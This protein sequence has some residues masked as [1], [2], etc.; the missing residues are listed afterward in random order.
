MTRDYAGSVPAPGEAT[1]TGRRHYPPDLAQF[2]QEAS[3]GVAVLEADGAVRWC[4][5]AEHER[6][7]LQR[8]QF[9]GRP[10]REVFVTPEDCDRLLDRLLKGAVVSG[11]VV[12]LRHASGTL[13]YVAIDGD[14]VT[15]DDGLH[16]RLLTRDVTAERL[17]QEEN[18]LQGAMLNA[19]GQAVVGTDTDGIVTY[20]NAAAERMFGVPAAEALGRDVFKL[21]NTEGPQPSGEEIIAA[22]ARGVPW[23][24]EVE[25]KRPDGSRLSVFV[26]ETP[27]LDADGRVVGYVGVSADISAL[28]EAAGELRARERR[29]EALAESLPAMVVLASNDRGFYYFNRTFQQYTGL[30]AAP[31]VSYWQELIHPD[32]FPSLREGFQRVLRGRA[33]EREARIRRHDGEF[34]WFLI[35]AVPLAPSR[36]EPG[37]AVITAVDIMDIRAASQRLESAKNQL[38]TILGGITDGVTAHDRSG[39]MVFANAAAARLLGFASVEELLSAPLTSLLRN[40]EVEDQ[41]GHRLKARDLPGVSVMRG[42]HPE[43]QLLAYK[44]RV[45]G[46]VRYSLV[47]AAAIHDS[48]GELEYVVDIFSDVTNTVLAAREREDLLQREREARISAE[49]TAYRLAALQEVTAS[50]AGALTQQQIAEVIVSSG[51][52][53]TGAQAAALA[54][55]EGDEVAVVAT[56]ATGEQ[57]ALKERRLRPDEDFPITAAISTCEE[58]FVCDVTDREGFPGIKARAW[59]A[60]PL[61]AED[62]CIGAVCFMFEQ[63]QE[64][65]EQD[66][67]MMRTLARL[68]SHAL[69]RARLYE[70]ETSLRS[71]AQEYADL[72]LRVQQVTDAA[73]SHP[74]LSELPQILEAIRGVVEADTISI[75]LLDESGRHL[76]AEASVGLE[77]EVEQRVRVPV[78]RGFV[79]RIAA[80]R[81]PAI[82]RE[83]ASY[84]F[85]EAESALRGLGSIAGIPLVVEGKVTGVLHVGLRQG[86][87]IEQRHVRLLELVADRVAQSVA[88]SRLF[89]AERAARAEAEDVRNRVTRL[90]ATTSRLAGA[91]TQAEAAAVVLEEG[92][93]H[94]RPETIVLALAQPGGGFEVLGSQGYSDA[95]LSALAA[96]KPSDKH[97]LNDIVAGAGPLFF[98]KMEEFRDRYPLSRATRKVSSATA[99]LPLRARDRVLGGVMVGFKE[100]REFGEADRNYIIAVV[101]QCALALARAQLYDAEIEARAEAQ[102]AE[103]RYRTLA[104]AM[105][106]IVWTATADGSV[107]YYNERFY[108]FTGLKPGQAQGWTWQGLVHPD[109]EGKVLAAWRRSLETGEQFELESRLRRADGSY[110]WVLERALPLR[111]A[112][113]RI[114]RWLGTVTDIDAQ[115]RAQERFGFLAEASA[116]LSS[117]LDFEETLRTVA[118]LAVPVLADWCAVHV[119]D[120]EGAP[121][122]LVIAGMDPNKWALDERMD[123]GDSMPSDAPFGYAYVLRTGRPQLVPEVAANPRSLDLGDRGPAGTEFKSAICVPVLVRGQVM[124]AISLATAESGRRYSERDL[125]TAI[126]FARHVAFAVENA[127]LYRKSQQIQEE[128]RLA[129]EA[130]DEFL[131]LMSHEL[132][133]PITTIFGGAKILRSRGRFLD[134][135][136]RES[137][138]RDIETEAEGMHRM[139]ED[140]L[141]LARTGTGE[142]VS[143]EPVLVNRLVDKVARGFQLHRPG[144]RILVNCEPDVLPAMAETTYLEQVLRNLLSNADK[145]SP[146]GLPIEVRIE[147]ADEEVIV[148]VLDRGPGIDPAEAELVFT[149]FYRAEKTAR[150]VRGMGLGLTVCKK[151]VEAQGGRIWARPRDGGGTEVSFAL[152]AFTASYDDV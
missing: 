123:V 109:D 48:A 102:D 121:M 28:K 99:C 148:S 23:S 132:R 70:L 30:A 10:Y 98:H 29:L 20:W 12:T 119:K 49:R 44:S 117:S 124:A 52:F 61:R 85:A 136:H 135:E 104:E 152:P 9:I 73:L 14:A 27:L 145:Y 72:L 151:L 45:T 131:G 107:D 4:N 86:G 15:L 22:H 43:P 79:G 77:G 84:P 80:S 116:T 150:N 146:P 88:Q 126:E 144:R 24:G 127:L 93:R 50:L 81:K 142:Q 11:E 95:A 7:G 51:V 16:F 129:N 115:K 8:E 143:T 68:C 106:Q 67:D 101:Q 111:D 21:V 38:E 34:R 122:R 97:P 76:V 33:L 60:L 69:D 46:E 114:T 40:F 108:E 65:A 110:C 71:Q 128:L 56:A 82:V 133:T 6:L 90:Q 1:G 42:E 64:F 5:R 3:I 74:D 17:S 32:D 103:A 63:E 140:L 78:G 25:V 37:T 41:D 2:V 62:H 31:E 59:A 13:R 94:L 137:L 130:K 75:F 87:S 92:L 125:E 113:G 39:R 89:Q 35:R 149:R 55:L 138:L 18:R 57:A 54:L 105:P 66:R 100:P 83:P 118:R 139:I 112:S 141:V 26:T 36:G 96:L 53:A 91:W 19:V 58:V 47:K 120:A 147:S 134:E